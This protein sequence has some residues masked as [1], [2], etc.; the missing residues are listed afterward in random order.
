MIYARKSISDDGNSE[1]TWKK[2]FLRF[3]IYIYTHGIFEK[4]YLVKAKTKK[5]SSTF[6]SHF[7]RKGTLVRSGRWGYN[8]ELMSTYQVPIVESAENLGTKRSCL[9]IIMCL[10]FA[11]YQE[12]GSGVLCTIGL[13]AQNVDNFSTKV[14]FMYIF[15][16]RIMSTLISVWLVL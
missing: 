16:T 6:S 11:L 12:K 3:D 10:F 5:L 13:T 14:K 4:S 2:V 8:H 15:P 7:S 9:A 1:K